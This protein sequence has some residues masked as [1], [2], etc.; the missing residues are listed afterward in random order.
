MSRPRHA[1]VLAGWTALLAAT[2][3][4]LGAAGS[5]PLAGP[6]LADAS[7]LG[8]WL[9]GRDAVTAAMAIV[10]VLLLGISW[11]LLAATLAGVVAAVVRSARLFAVADAVSV[12]AV[13]RLVHGAVGLGL[14]AAPLAAAAVAPASPASAQ[15][16]AGPVDLGPLTMERLPDPTPPAAAPA[17]PPAAAP[18]A[19]PAA[20]PA[21]APDEW[22]VAPGDH[23]WS[24]AERRLAAARGHQPA[25]AEVAPY[26]RAL[27]AANRDRLPD[28]DLLFPGQRLRLP[29]T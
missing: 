18:A 19:P 28:P 7:L 16:A 29:P 9:Q 6:P 3:A 22:T 24:I 17:A 13:R 12:P 21:A 11:Y 8:P 27:I 1:L 2:I 4:G 20:A 5:G 26:W 25:D 23:L 15:A 14:A 10:R